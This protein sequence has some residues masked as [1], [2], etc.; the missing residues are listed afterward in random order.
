MWQRAA[1]ARC[2]MQAFP[3]VVFSATGAAIE[4]C[5]DCPM[6]S[7]PFAV[8]RLP[9]ALVALFLMFTAAPF[10]ASPV[11]AGEWAE[12]SEYEPDENEGDP[13]APSRA[14]SFGPHMPRAR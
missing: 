14:R 6:R 4:S 12:W 1:E 8:R 3:V 9:P 11:G 7:A 2:H 13:P 5:E 10:L